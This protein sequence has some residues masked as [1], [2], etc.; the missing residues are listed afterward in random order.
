VDAGWSSAVTAAAAASLLDTLAAAFAAVDSPK[1][2]QQA[3]VLSRDALI[4]ASSRP[5]DTLQRFVVI[6]LPHAVRRIRPILIAYSH[7]MAAEKTRLEPYTGPG[8]FERTLAAA[9]LAWMTTQLNA[10]ALHDVSVLPSLLPSVLACLDDPAPAVQRCG[11]AA[12]THIALTASAD[13]LAPW[14]EVLPDAARKAVVG[15]EE[16]VWPGAAVALVAVAAKLQ[17]EGMWFTVL[18]R[19]LCISYVYS[20]A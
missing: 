9:Q 5:L 11:L 2:T 17:G 10:E 6:A 8:T 14:A 7:H 13:A 19:C 12:V 3:H 15:C 4:Q 18:A 16:R 1:D 20:A